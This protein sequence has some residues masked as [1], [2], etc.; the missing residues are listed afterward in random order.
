MKF[1]HG[2]PPFPSRRYAVTRPHDHAMRLQT[3]KTQIDSA[4]YAVD[5]QEVAEALLRYAER[6]T[7]QAGPVDDLSDARRGARTRRG[8]PRSPRD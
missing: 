2:P 7:Q 4:T 1:R 8:R 5:P 3:L 6:H